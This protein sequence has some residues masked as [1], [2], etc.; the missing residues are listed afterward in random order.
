MGLDGGERGMRKKMSAGNVN[1]NNNNQEALSKACFPTP[2]AHLLWTGLDL[3]FPV[4]SA[5]PLTPL[6]S[7]GLA[8]LLTLGWP[9]PWSCPIISENEE[10]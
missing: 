3:A 8:V 4:G 9:N 10:T 6:F 2:V 1:S 5:L 7:S